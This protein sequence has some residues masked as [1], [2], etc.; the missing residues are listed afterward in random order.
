MFDGYGLG[1]K[2]DPD[3]APYATDFL[4]NMRRPVVNRPGMQVVKTFKCDVAVSPLRYGFRRMKRASE[5]ATIH[6]CDCRKNCWAGN[7]GGLLTTKKPP[8]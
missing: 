1:Q 4:N 2:D 3:V 8:S 7:V 6:P 5:R